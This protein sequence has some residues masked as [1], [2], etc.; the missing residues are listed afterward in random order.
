[1]TK[2]QA[3]I[4]RFEALEKEI[5]TDDYKRQA[6]DEFDQARIGKRVFQMEDVSRLF[7]L[8]DNKS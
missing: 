6:G 3:R 4:H 1:M 5:K 2:E 7:R 8:M